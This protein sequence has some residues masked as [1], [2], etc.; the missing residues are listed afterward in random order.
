MRTPICSQPLISPQFEIIAQVP[1][2]ALPETGFP[3]PVPIV[4][5]SRVLHCQNKNKRGATEFSE[6]TST[7]RKSV[8]ETVSFGSTGCGCD[9]IS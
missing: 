6:T 3:D 8:M 9:L 4:A 1:R 7:R 2:N 5:A